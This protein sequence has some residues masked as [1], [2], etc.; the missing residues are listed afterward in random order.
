[1]RF[2]FCVC[3]TKAIVARESALEFNEKIALIAHHGNVKDER[4]GP[5]YFKKFDLVRR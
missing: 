3:I 5:A 1:M 2:D 4:F